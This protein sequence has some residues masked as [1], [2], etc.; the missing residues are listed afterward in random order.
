M[1]IGSPPAR[2]G[3]P[4]DFP[5]PSASMEVPPAAFEDWLRSLDGFGA[6][7]VLALHPVEGGASNVILRASLADAPLPAVLLR[8]QRE[9]GIFEPYDVLREA[10]VLRRLHPSPVPVPRVVGEE[11]DGAVLGAPFVVLEWV[12]A[13]H[14]GVAGPEA[15]FSAYAAM[16]ARIHALD[17]RALGLDEVL[18]VP[19]SAAAAT[20]AELEV[21]AGRMERFP[22]ADAPI[23]RRA[24]AILR[25]R[26]PGGAPVGFCQ[27]DINVFNYLFRGG[28]V[29]AV[30][31][32]EQARLGDTR[33]D[34]AQVLALG[35]LKGAPFGPVRDQFFLQ[36]Y[37]AARG[38][39]ELADMAFFRARWLFELGVIYH[40]W[41]AFN[42]DLPWYGW[43][44]LEELLDLALAELP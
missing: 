17:W 3:A 27:G 42:D 10:A 32:W 15:S 13:P 44:H 34:V 24:L 33:N 14:M 40:G 20:S 7:G 1:S 35:H 16:V 31:D 30:V 8:L 9:R 28:E 43:N 38:E 12:D 4:P 11:A 18:P 37:E 36:A 6:A 23:L 29:A 2:L 25:E 19:D 21:I 39:G 26:V 41:R 22:G 5:V